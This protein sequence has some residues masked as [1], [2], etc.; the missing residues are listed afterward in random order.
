VQ[1]SSNCWALILA[2]GSGTR[3]SGLTSDGAG[4]SVPKQFCSLAG[5]ASLLEETLVR[6]AAIAAP[7]QTAV[8]VAGEHR[9]FW[10]GA[11]AEVASENVIVQPRNRGTAN[12]LLL[13]LSAILER[14]QDAVVAILPSDHFVEREEVMARALERAV[15]AVEA[16]KAPSITFLGIAPD[17]ADP[18]L[19]Y[20]VPGARQFDG[21]HRITR[22]V[23]KPAR[24][25]AVRM[26]RERALWNS[27]ILVARASAL[28]ALIEQRYPVEVAAFRSLFRQ[29]ALTERLPRELERLY[30]RLP[31]I[32]FSRDVV[33]GAAAP[34]GVVAVPR[35]GWSDLGTP[36]RVADCLARLGRVQARGD[37]RDERAAGLSRHFNLADAY[38]RLMG[39]LASG[40]TA[41]TA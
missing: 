13:G 23:E 40:S 18:E 7:A 41:Q 30:E 3:L 24:A 27:F 36:Q 16:S 26:V 14:D 17:A 32:D 4:T 22:F 21:T 19:G 28:V 8:I 11:L 20:I 12:G 1:K 25:I 5:G 29:T 9:R 10:H 38:A 31:E 6:A 33:E 34:L 37:G 35:C 39:R 2:A 15:A